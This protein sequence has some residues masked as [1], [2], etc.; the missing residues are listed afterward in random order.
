[1]WDLI[2]GVDERIEG[3][4]LLCVE[5]LKAASPAMLSVA[6]SVIVTGAVIGICIGL[7]EVTYY[8]YGKNKQDEL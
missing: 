4:R 3:L 8:K 1:M 6:F 7:C 2:K 5:S